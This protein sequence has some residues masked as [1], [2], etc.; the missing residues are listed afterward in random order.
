MLQGVARSK[1]EMN[2]KSY[3]NW[4]FMDLFMIND[5]RNFYDL[6]NYCLPKS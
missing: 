4:D 1:K 5:S 6:C 2:D 3:E